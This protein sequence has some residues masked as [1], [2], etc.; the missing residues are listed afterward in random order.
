MLDKQIK[1]ITDLQ[2]RLELQEQQA[3]MERER[4]EAALESIKRDHQK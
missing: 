2:R 3:K 1:E 4:D